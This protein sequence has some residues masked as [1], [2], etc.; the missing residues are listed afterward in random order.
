MLYESQGE[1]ILIKSMLWLKTIT[2][3]IRE[4][5]TI[6]TIQFNFFSASNKNQSIMSQAFA[7]CTAYMCYPFIAFHGQLFVCYT[8]IGMSN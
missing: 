4:C 1:I 5:D 3:R 7:H 2:I 6:L 8:F